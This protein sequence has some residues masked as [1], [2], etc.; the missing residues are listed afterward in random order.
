MEWQFS[1]VGLS[2][3]IPR[4]CKSAQ[5]RWPR[6]CMPAQEPVCQ[7]KRLRVRHFSFVVPSECSEEAAGELQPSQPHMDRLN[8]EFCCWAEGL[9]SFLALLTGVAG[10]DNYTGHFWMP[11]LWISA[12]QLTLHPLQEGLLPQ[13]NCQ[14]Q[15][16]QNLCSALSKTE[17]LADSEANS[18]PFY[19]FHSH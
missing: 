14:W 18:I 6:S 13:L 12:L 1:F 10:G 16:S 15:D 5:P 3:L 2:G 11:L 19:P 7:H 8:E 17:L 9:W 4:W